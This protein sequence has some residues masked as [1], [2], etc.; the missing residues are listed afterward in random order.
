[1]LENNLGY[2]Q[3]HTFGQD[4]RDELR[5]NLKSILN[6]K[7]DGLIIDFRN[8]GGGYLQTAVEV[9]SEFIAKD[10]IL[11]EEY[12]SD[13]ALEEFKALN[14]GLATEIPLVVLVNE[15]S[16]SAS[17]I[18]AG[19]IQDHDRGPLVGATTFGKG[20]VQNWIELENNQGAV[21]VTIA[22]WLTPDQRQIN[23]SGLDPDYPVELTEEDYENE[24]DPQLDKAVEVLLDLIGG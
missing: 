11:Y 21:R 8:N 5:N 18:V 16:A 19:A 7:P 1:M 4:T 14:G 20:S 3:I 12:G 13:E 15:G 10:T 24:L 17:E 2:I 9:A 23:S 6:Q 22:R